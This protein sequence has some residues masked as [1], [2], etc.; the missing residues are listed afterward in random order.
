V[1]RVLHDRLQLEG[2]IAVEVIDQRRALGVHQISSCG[3][4]RREADTQAAHGGN[5]VAEAR[6]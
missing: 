1:E 3:G 5:L 2:E 6:A 4:S